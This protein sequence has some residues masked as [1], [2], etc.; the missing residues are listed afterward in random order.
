LDPLI[1]RRRTPHFHASQTFIAAPTQESQEKK[2]YLIV[3]M[4]GQRDRP[5][6]QRRSR[7]GKEFM[8]HLSRGHF[9][10]Q[11]L[12]AGELRNIDPRLDHAQ[13]E[14]CGGVHDQSLVRITAAAADE[15][16]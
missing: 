1:R 9:N 6:L 10:R 3:G 4:M 14:S 16:V 13:S 11:L 12:L 5:E 8:T 15:V 7:S 2:F